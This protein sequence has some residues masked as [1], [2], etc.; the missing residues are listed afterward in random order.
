MALPK[1][2]VA[3]AIAIFR[4]IEP[5]APKKEWVRGCD[6][7]ELHWIIMQD[8]K[9][10]GGYEALVINIQD[11]TEAQVKIWNDNRKSVH[12]TSY[13]KRLPNNVTRLGFF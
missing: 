2:E 4:M 7:D 6:E 13:E 3:K 9:Y 1:S 10:D 11:I 8:E 5:G 12:N